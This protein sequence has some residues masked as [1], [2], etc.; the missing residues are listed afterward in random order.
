M[1]YIQLKSPW[2]GLETV[3]ECATRAE[4]RALCREYTQAD[5]TGFYYV[6]RRACKAWAAK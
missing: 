4:A 5:P 1:F 3:D 6:S 2:A